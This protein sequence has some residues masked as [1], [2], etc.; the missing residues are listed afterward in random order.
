MNWENEEKSS[1]IND[2]GLKSSC[3]N[4]NS[5]VKFVIT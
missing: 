3:W 4:L 2:F 5:L 1:L